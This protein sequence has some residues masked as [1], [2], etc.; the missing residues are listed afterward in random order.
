MFQWMRCAHAPPGWDGEGGDASAACFQWLVRKPG[1]DCALHEARSF[2]CRLPLHPAT[3][4]G[5]SAGHT[6]PG[7]GFIIRPRSRKVLYSVTAGFSHYTQLLLLLLPADGFPKSTLKQRTAQEALLSGRSL[8]SG[9]CA[10]RSFPLD[11]R[12]HREDRGAGE[13]GETGGTG[14]ARSGP[15]CLWSLEGERKGQRQHRKKKDYRW[16][17]LQKGGQER[18]RVA[19]SPQSVKGFLAGGMA[20]VVGGVCTHPWI[21]SK[22]ECR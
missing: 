1:Q 14:Q 19:G 3:R 5:H 22:S 8:S 11:S 13:T 9:L 4:V 7:P 6:H 2:E 20:A 10:S 15:P 18:R 12:P 21:S 16:R 17:Q